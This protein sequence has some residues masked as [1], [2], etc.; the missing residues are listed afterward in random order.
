MSDTL[1]RF[2]DHYYRYR[3]VN[4]TFTGVHSFDDRLPDWSLGG[5]AEMDS[6]MRSLHGELM[7]ASPPA[8][9]L[10]QGDPQQLDITLARSFLEIQLA[11]NDCG[12][13]RRGTPARWVGE[14][15][16]SIISLMIRP[17]APLNER[18]AS[19]TARLS[20]IPSFLQHA[21]L[22]IGAR[23][24]PESWMMK[25]LRECEGAEVLLTDGMA[26]WV[27][28][29][30]HDESLD[31][32]LL[33]AA[34]RARMGFDRFAVWL[35]N[36][37]AAPESAMGCGTE[38]FDLLLTHGHMCPTPRAE[39]LANARARLIEAR[40]KLDEMARAAS[41]S[42]AEAQNA[43]ASRHPT[44]NEYFNTFHDTWHACHALAQ[45]RDVVSWPDWP[46]RY[47]AY[48]EF[49]AAAAPFLYYLHYRS[50]APF[51]AYTIHDYVVPAPPVANGDAFLR[52]WN[53]GTIKLN[54]VVHHGAIGHHVQNW[55]AYH[56][57]SSRVGQVAAVDCANRIGMFCA[58]TMAEGWACYATQLMDELGFLTPLEQVSEQHTRVRMLAR[59]VVD[60][61]LHQK[62]MSFSDAIRFYMEQAGMPEPAA[63]GEATKNSMFP[64]TAI[65]Y[66]LGTKGILDLRDA[67]RAQRGEGFTLR[68]FHDD[69]LSRGSIPVA[70]LS[71]LMTQVAA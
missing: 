51:D 26:K 44:V 71:R 20:A 70:L 15:V 28:S 5:L 55:H 69:V 24:L 25:A 53:D 63:R 60:I 12:H 38:L 19:A 2:F 23:R 40:A 18:L 41:G 4:A 35:R 50:P 6:Q 33:A 52:T 56:Q 54:H 10:L 46:I 13:G 1:D 39:L 59:A 57:S 11:E 64:C 32:G 61:E 21:E 14:S 7:Q 30:V 17:F 36:R 22:T 48:P 34:G 43:L 3:P 58:G 49:T 31:A 45:S 62:S 42:W 65:M 27:A 68:A 37:S 47:V 67:M 9:T 16:F 66:W 29:E 8:A